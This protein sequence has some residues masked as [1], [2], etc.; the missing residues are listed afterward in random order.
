M[1]MEKYISSLVN[2]ANNFAQSTRPKHIGTLSLLMEEYKSSTKTPSKDGW[3]SFYRMR[4][5]DSVIEQA[6][7]RT[8]EKIEQIRNN[9]KS[10]EKEDVYDWVRS[11]IIDKTYD[12]LMIQAILLEEEAKK[13]NQPWRMASPEEESKG[14]DGFV[15]D[16]PYSVKPNTYCVSSASHNENINYKMLFYKQQKK[17]GK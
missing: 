9:L 14:I 11:L 7:D 1:S 2:I 16:V 12:G 10:L 17:T 15:G 3:E 4:M 5:G 13:T 8:W 6:T